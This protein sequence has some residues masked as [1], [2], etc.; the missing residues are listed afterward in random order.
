MAVQP[1]INDPSK[2]SEIFPLIMY[3]FKLGSGFAVA[4][5]IY[6]QPLHRD[7][8]IYFIIFCGCCSGSTTGAA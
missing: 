2:S 1:N 5:M 8:V 4:I 3:R 6:G 7:D